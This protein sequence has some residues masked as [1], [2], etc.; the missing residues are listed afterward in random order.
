[1]ATISILARCLSNHFGLEKHLLARIHQLV[2]GSELTGV[3]GA[4]FMSCLTGEALRLRT[5]ELGGSARK[6]V[7]SIHKLLSPFPRR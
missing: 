5:A 3:A 2:F 7:K 4:S 1:M 6:P